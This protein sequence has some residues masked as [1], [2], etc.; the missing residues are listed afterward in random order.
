[1]LKNHRPYCG[2]REF[3]TPTGVKITWNCC[4]GAKPRIPGPTPLLDKL[5]EEG[6][7]YVEH[8][9]THQ[10][11]RVI[12]R[13]ADGVEVM[14]GEDVSLDAARLAAEGYLAANPSPEKW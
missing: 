6:H 1:M 4:C 5:I 3:T 14:L 9:K 12:G 13:A 11:V 10:V 8:S 2:A 7:A